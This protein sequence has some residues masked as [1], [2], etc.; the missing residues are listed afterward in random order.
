MF[1]QRR[2]YVYPLL[3]LMALALGPSTAITDRIGF[4][5]TTTSSAGASPPT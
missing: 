4:I 2:G 1:T 5:A 3:G